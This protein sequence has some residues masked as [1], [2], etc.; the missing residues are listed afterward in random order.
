[1]AK[2]HGEIE[3]RDADSLAASPHNSRRHPTAQIQAIAESIRRFGFTRPLLILESGEL[4]AGHGAMAAAKLLSMASVPCRVLRGMT[5]DQA[6]AYIVADN[7]LSEMS[8]WDNEAL[9]S[10]LEWAGE[11]GID[12]G[13]L[14]F[15]LAAL[16]T[17]VDGA[18][19]SRELDANA[20]AERDHDEDQKPAKNMFPIVLSLTRAQWLRWQELKKAGDLS[21]TDLF[22]SMLN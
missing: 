14:D 15:D 7:R 5:S 10:E 6:R 20:S 17:D 11:N 1:M 22:A 13:F 18:L 8:E 9:L 19:D 4:V 3:Y 16:D 2:V 21:D 12:L